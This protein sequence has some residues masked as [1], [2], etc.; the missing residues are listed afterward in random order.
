MASPSAPV[1]I[2]NLACDAMGEGPISSVEIP[3][4]EKEELF[5][6]HYDQVRRLVLREQV[7]NFAQ[8]YRE[9]ARTGNGEG[10]F[11]DLYAL[12][13]D[14]VRFNG[15]GKNLHCQ[16]KDYELT[17]RAILANQGSSLILR[18]NR[19][20]T[21]V[22]SMD[23]AFINVF[24]LR[25]ALKTAFKITKKKSVVETIEAMLKIEEPKAISVDG[26]ERPPIRTQRSKYL[27]AR[28]R[29]SANT[30]GRY[31]EFD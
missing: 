7:W 15:I 5:A 27:S 18:Y 9:I 12:P 8:K 29:N 10:R 28:R 21:N 24:A 19:D 25:L 13:N 23:A 26:Q 3:A 16:V 2:C 22:A 14:F 4:T 6:R 1:D 20:I 17:E 11:A 31:Y 30:S